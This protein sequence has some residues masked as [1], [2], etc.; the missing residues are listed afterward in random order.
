[1]KKVNST[2]VAKAA[3]VAQS[4][5]SLV[6][7]NSPRVA[8]ET[9]RKVIQA[10]RIL[11]YSLQPRDKRLMIGIIIS[12]NHPVKSWQATVLSSLKT[13]IYQRNYRM[14]IICS[15]DIPLLH[16]RLVSGAI[17]ITSDPAQNLLWKDLKN[18]PLVRLNGYSSHIDNIY[19]VTTDAAADMTKLYN[20]LYEA[21][22]RR[23]GL[24]LDKTREQEQAE[25]L[26][27]CRAFQMQF[28][29]HESAIRPDKLISFHEKDR[30]VADR[31]KV[32]LKQGVTGLIVIPGDMALKVS[33]ELTKL[34]KQIPRDISLVTVEYPGVCEN[35]SPPLTSLSRDYPAI[36]AGSLNLIEAWLERKTVSDLRIPGTMIFRESV[37]APGP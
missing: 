24:F 3:G 20:C 4:T 2:M 11:G 33:R 30:S 16:D 28:W 25:G 35:W 10:A 5:V 8:L 15:E 1:M 26:S 13:E 23:I 22:H 29:S 14:E 9:R 21:G 36:C 6:V 12:R 27:V 37:A 19:N 7:N 34:G 17:S 18:I 31:L 32:Q